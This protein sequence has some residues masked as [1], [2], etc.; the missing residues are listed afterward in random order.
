MIFHQSRAR[1]CEQAFPRQGERNFDGLSTK[2]RVSWSKQSLTYW[3]LIFISVCCFGL[4]LLPISLF[5]EPLRIAY[6]SIAMTYGPLWLTKEAGIFKKYNI[7]P[8]MLY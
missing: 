3:N 2:T 4:S 5:A 1:D 8:E 7:E 6:T